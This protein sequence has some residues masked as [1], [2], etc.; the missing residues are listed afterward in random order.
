M[1]VAWLPVGGS[2]W[3]WLRVLTKLPVGGSKWVWLRVLTKLPV[4]GSKWVWRRVLS[5]LS[6]THRLPPTGSYTVLCYLV[7]RLVSYSMSVIH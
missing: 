7:I 4:G 3:V 5:T 1:G 6:C 2:K